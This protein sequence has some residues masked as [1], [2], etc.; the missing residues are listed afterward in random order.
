MRFLNGFLFLI[1][2]LLFFPI[3][4]LA[5]AA[6]TGIVDQFASQS[7]FAIAGEI[8]LMMSALAAAMPARWKEK[9]DETQRTWY[10]WLYNS[11]EFLAVNIF[12][13][14]SKE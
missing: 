6:E 13:A 1:S 11:V 10:K 4:V 9:K 12:H 2:I 5:Q 14:K 8:V 3:L 7:W